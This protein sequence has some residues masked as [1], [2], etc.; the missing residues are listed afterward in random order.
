MIGAIK[1]IMNM[2]SVESANLA[3]SN[4]NGYKKK[5]ASIDSS[6]NE[7]G[8]IGNDLYTKTDYRQGD[9]AQTG[10]KSDL[11]IQGDGMFILFDGNQKTSFDPNQ[12]L[13]T[14]N[15]NKTFAQ[16]ITSGTFTVN[17]NAVVVDVN[18]DSYNDVLNKINMATAGQITGTYDKIKNSLTLADTSGVPGGNI[19]LG[20]GTSNFLDV[21]SISDSILQKGSGNIVFKESSLP[22]GVMAQNAQMY[23]TRKGDFNFDNNGFL[24]NSQGLYVAGIDERTGGLMRIDKKAFDG[25]GNASDDVNFAA[26]GVLFNSTQLVKE[27]KQLALAKFPNKNGLIASR[28]G[29]EIL[30]V[31][32]NAGRIKIDSPD[33]SNLGLIRDQS[34]EQSNSSAVDSLT[35][36]G[37]LQRFFPSTVNALKVTLSAQDD[38]NKF[39]Q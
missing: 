1:N 16:N 27:G 22:I 39:I 8:S 10:Q 25:S 36:L 35:N 14:L 6:G 4:V 38:L 19:L 29:G 5:T 34:L 12:K 31:T 15:I 7:L 20:T 30:S 9:I 33:K 3:G 18:N 28:Y 23:F 32:E 37:V 24:V 21:S 2:I 26:N 11:A 13:S 17:G